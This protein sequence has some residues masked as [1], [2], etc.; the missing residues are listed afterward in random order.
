MTA[1]WKQPTT[2]GLAEK[3]KELN[4]QLQEILPMLEHVQGEAIQRMAET[5]CMGAGGMGIGAGKADADQTQEP[6]PK[7]H[8]QT[9]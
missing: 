7:S 4:R 6:S 1:Q 3:L 8:E 2:L 5:A 9:E